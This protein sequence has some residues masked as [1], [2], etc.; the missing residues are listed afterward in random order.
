MQLLR[1]G[2]SDQLLYPSTG[3]EVNEQVEAAFRPIQHNQISKR[4]R[5]AR[6]PSRQRARHRIAATNAFL[7]GAS[8]SDQVVYQYDH[9]QDQQEMN[10]A[11]ATTYTGYKTQ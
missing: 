9:S 10:Q 5:I 1:R 6:G 3:R 2:P 8:A 11:G 4:Q 7:D